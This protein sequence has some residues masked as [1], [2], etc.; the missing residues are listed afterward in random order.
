M[1]NTAT[2]FFNLAPARL[3]NIGEY[4]PKWGVLSMPWFLLS[5]RLTNT[6]VTPIEANN[7]ALSLEPDR[8][9]TG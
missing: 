8:D 7:G 4:T 9:A 2:A 1:E 5:V 3:W 6:S